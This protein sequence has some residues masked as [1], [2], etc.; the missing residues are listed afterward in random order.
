MIRI[1]IAMPEADCKG[2]NPV[3]AQKIKI[4]AESTCEL[5]REYH[6]VSLLEIHMI[7][8]RIYREMVR[9]PSARILVVCEPCHRHIHKL[10]VLVKKQRAIVKDRPFHMRQDMRRVLGYK[11]KPY[12]PP[13]T[14]DLA[15]IYEDY[16]NR[17]PPGSFRMAG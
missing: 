9:D 4:A 2:I 12:L 1:G 15:Q 11:P 16:F 14:I 8:R 13:D 7:S 10:P 5:C 17:I 3:Q 6:P